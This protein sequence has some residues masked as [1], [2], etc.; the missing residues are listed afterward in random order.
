MPR[1]RAGRPRANAP[2]SRDVRSVR[3]RSCA[4]GLLR[5]EPDWIPEAI[6]YGATPVGF[7]T[8]MDFAAFCERL[9][10]EALG[11]G[12]SNAS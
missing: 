12:D 2:W 10:N 4:D 7:P 8:R 3:V 1:N 5:V 9:I 11:K 6:E